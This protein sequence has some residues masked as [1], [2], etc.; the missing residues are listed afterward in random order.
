MSVS[1]VQT[2][3]R[4]KAVKALPGSGSSFAPYFEA[5]AERPGTECAFRRTALPAGR[6][7]RDCR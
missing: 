7:L 4:E 6:I 3:S 2:T 5:L 1:G